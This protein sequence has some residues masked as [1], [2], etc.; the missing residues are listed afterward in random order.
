M[1]DEGVRNLCRVFLVVGRAQQNYGKLAV[2]QLAVLRRVVDVRGEFDSVTH[3]NHYV[4][5]FANAVADIGLRAE[6]SAYGEHDQQAHKE[7]KRGD[8]LVFKAPHHLSLYRRKALDEFAK[9]SSGAR[10]PLTRPRG[11]A[12][13]QKPSRRPIRPSRRFSGRM[14]GKP[15]LG[16]TS[17]LP[18]IWPESEPSQSR[19]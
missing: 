14:V 12:I 18:V 11:H 5:C 10:A 19:S 7:G 8:E 6:R 15:Y 4:F 13:E 1:G 16:I 3:G 9:G 17:H 2:N